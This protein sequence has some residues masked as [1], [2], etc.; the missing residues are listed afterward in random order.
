VLPGH[1]V[2]AHLEKGSGLYAGRAGGTAAGGAGVALR[3]QGGRHGSA[4]PASQL[5]A[6]LR[7]RMPELRFTPCAGDIFMPGR[8][9]PSPR[10]TG[11]SAVFRA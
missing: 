5:R 9:R 10:P 6:A 1:R 11:L 3:L 4:S 8:R 2:G 7:W